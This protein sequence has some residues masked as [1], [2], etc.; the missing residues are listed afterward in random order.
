MISF[1]CILEELRIT[2]RSEIRKK[3]VFASNPEYLNDFHS[4]NRLRIGK[5]N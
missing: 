3:N 4:E 5:K 2:N 1:I